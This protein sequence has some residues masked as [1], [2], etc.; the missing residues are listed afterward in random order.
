[1]ES[2]KNI[3]CCCGR[4]PWSMQGKNRR[5]TKCNDR[6]CKNRKHAE[7]TNNVQRQR[8]HNK[9]Y[10]GLKRVSWQGKTVCLWDPCYLSAF[11]FLGSLFFGS[12]VF[13]VSLLLKSGKVAD[14]EKGK[15]CQAVLWGVIL[16]VDAFLQSCE[17]H[18]RMAPSF[19]PSFLPSFFPSFFL[20]FL[21]SF[22]PSY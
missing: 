11:S 9:R 4:Q 1:M 15:T 6:T 14:E 22:L 2:D 8:K 7:P 10:A 21:L 16:Q 5:N 18:C 12:L 19:I 3:R 13:V 20:S 17:N